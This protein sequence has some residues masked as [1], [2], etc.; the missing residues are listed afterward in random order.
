LTANLTRIEAD[1]GNNQPLVNVNYEFGGKDVLVDSRKYNIVVPG[2]S[3]DSQNRIESDKL[4]QERKIQREVLT[5]ELS[6]RTRTLESPAYE[7]A[8]V[9]KLYADTTNN[10]VKFALAQAKISKSVGYGGRNGINSY[11]PKVGSVGVEKS[12]RHAVYITKVEGEMITFSESNYVK[13]YI[14]QRTLPKSSFLGFI[15]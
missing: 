7:N 3:I 9:T 14:T 4:L 8:N 11:E 5:R 2:T 15:E 12:I 6:N 10:C 13:N 1:H